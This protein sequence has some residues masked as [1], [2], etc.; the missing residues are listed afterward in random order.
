MTQPVTEPPIDEP[1]ACCDRLPGHARRPDAAMRWPLL[2]RLNIERA[3]DDGD[4]LAIR[5]VERY[6]IS[7][8]WALREVADWRTW[9]TLRT[10]S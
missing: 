6:G 8:D 4:L 3:G 5:I 2:S 9:N 10:I 1:T 7:R